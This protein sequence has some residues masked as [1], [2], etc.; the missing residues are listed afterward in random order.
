MTNSRQ[1]GAVGE[2]EWSK[3]LNKTLGLNSR[4]GCQ[5]AGGPDSPDV[6]DGVPGTHVEVKR[7]ERLNIQSAMEQ[8]LRD[9]GESIPYVA[10]RRN[11]KQW[12]VTLQA[13]DLLAFIEKVIISQQVERVNSEDT[14]V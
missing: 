7:V 12:L 11:N 1:K 13:D 8:A 2:R 4:R 5:H 3:W 6:V 14:R 9:C 10:H